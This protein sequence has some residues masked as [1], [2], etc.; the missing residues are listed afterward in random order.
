MDMGWTMPTPSATQGNAAKPDDDWGNAG[1]GFSGGSTADK[2]PENN[3]FQQ[4]GG[5]AHTSGFNNDLS[6]SKAS[7]SA[8]NTNQVTFIKPCVVLL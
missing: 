4:A 7:N 6:S 8:A 2:P 5:N 1:W 3:T